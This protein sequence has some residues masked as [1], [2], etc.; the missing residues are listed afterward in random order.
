VQRNGPILIRDTALDQIV[1]RRVRVL[2]QFHGSLRYR[3]AQ[4]GS[5]CRSSSARL[6]R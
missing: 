5:I 6:R 2:D 1:E 3:A 4:R